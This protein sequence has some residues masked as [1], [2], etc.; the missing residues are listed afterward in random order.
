MRHTARYQRSFLSSC[1]TVRIKTLPSHLINQIA[2]GEVVERPASAI[3]ELLENSLDAGAREVSVEVERGGMRLMRVRD[4]GSGMNAEELP[5]ALA[6]HATSKIASLDDLER[7]AS[8]GFRGEALP[9]IASVADLAITSR[10]VGTEHGWC[11]QATQEGPGEPR[12]AAHPPGTTVEVRDLFHNVP[13]RRKFL[14]TERTEFGHIEQVVRRLALSRFD[15]SVRLSHNGRESFALAAGESQRAREERIVGLCGRAFLDNALHVDHAASGLRLHGWLAEPGFSR[16]QPDLQHFYVNGRMVRDK[17]VAHAVRRA[18]EDVLH[19]RRFPA[20]VLYLELDPRLVDVNAH[21][22]KHEV[23]FREARLVHDFL[24]AT[25]HH[26]LEAQHPGS[27][28]THRV[29]LA[30]TLPPQAASPP[31]SER[32]PPAPPGASGALGLD[33]AEAG[34]LYG[35]SLAARGESAYSS[36]VARGAAGGRETGEAGEPPLGFALGQLHGIYIVA[37][38]REG[39]VLV[40]MHA[41]HERV[42]YERMKARF[43]RDGRVA[44]QP[45]LVPLWLEVMPQEADL[46]EAMSRVLEQL[47]LEIDRAGLDTLCIRAAPAL[48]PSG[49]LEALVRDVLSDVAAHDLEA[50][51]ASRLE[52]A[53]LSILGNMACKSAIKAH[54]TLTLSEMN[55]LLRDMEKTDRSGQCNHGRPSWIQLDIDGLDRLFMRGQ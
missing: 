52:A 10:A 51:D 27:T 45:L 49:D 30:P 53:L 21:P 44:S 38:N 33:V 2:A 26:A 7:V 42:L 54:R 29:E 36:G 18:Y 11:L 55:A 28:H 35:P 24:F 34:S 4:D 13:A 23:R 6:R 32:S 46:A 17:L 43:L 12:P 15:V 1:P 3:K 37:Q 39:L 47:G 8:L 48:V 19:N 5:M 40:D 16:A 25:L 9:S 31:S 20:F 22:A 41:G 50:A 14:K